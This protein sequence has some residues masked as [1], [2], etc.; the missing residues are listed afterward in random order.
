M[1]MRRRAFL[2]LAP[3]G[4]LAAWLAPGAVAQAR[5]RTRIVL[6]GTAGGPFP[7]KGRSAPAAAVVV[8]EVAYVV[9]CGNGVARQFVLAGLDLSRIRHVFV[10]HHHS[11]HNAD[12]GTLLLLAWTAGLKTPVD[13][14]GPPPLSRMTELFFDMSAPDI[15][16]RIAD[17]ARPPLK[18]LIHAHD[19]SAGGVVVKDERVTVRCA[20]VHHPMVPVALAYRFDGPDRSVVFSGDTTRSDALLA[21]AR[22]A[23]VLV[24]EVLYPDPYAAAAAADERSIAKHIIESHTPVEEVGRLAQEAGVKTLVL[25]HFVPDN[26]AD[27]ERSWLPLARKHFRGEVIVGRDL[28]EI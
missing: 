4:A 5:H 17:E 28:L 9:D 3:A 18:P 23:D 26:N 22:G 20:V 24:H 13:T 21:L 19:V 10:T 27:A 1:T 25:T 14:W 6:L 12:F 7:K 11:D 2:R 16:I 15:D 8:D